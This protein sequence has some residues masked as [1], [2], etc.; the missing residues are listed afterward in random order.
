MIEKYLDYLSK[1]NFLILS[2]LDRRLEKS[3]EKEMK[4]QLP[5]LTYLQSYKMTHLILLYYLQYQY[6]KE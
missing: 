1:K 2:F 5:K 6:K 4:L 3:Y